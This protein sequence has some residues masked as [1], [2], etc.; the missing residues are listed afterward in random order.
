MGKNRR[1]I[2]EFNGLDNFKTDFDITKKKSTK[3]VNEWINNN[4]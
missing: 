4:L 1:E 3:N 2:L